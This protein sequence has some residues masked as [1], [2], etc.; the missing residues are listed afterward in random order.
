MDILLYYIRDNLTGTHYFIYAFILFFFMFSIIGYLFK[1]KYAKLEIKLDTSQ[2]SKEQKNTQ[3]ISNKE[4]STQVKGIPE[5]T[6]INQNSVKVA[7]TPIKTSQVI[8]RV[9]SKP[10]SNVT[11]Q[12]STVS[13][14]TKTTPPVVS[15]ASKPQATTTNTIEKVSETPVTPKIMPSPSISIT[16]IPTPIP[17]KPSTDIKANPISTET[18][19]ITNNEPIPEIKL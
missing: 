8:N 11:E 14:V 10:V 18:P 17:A 3:K 2:K 9:E 4:Q 16:P 19:K 7:S 5:G 6:I 1:E 15:A 13:P 12:S